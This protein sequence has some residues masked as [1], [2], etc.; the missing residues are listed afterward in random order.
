[1]GKRVTS[2]SAMVMWRKMVL[3]LLLASPPFP[4]IRVYRARLFPTRDSRINPKNADLVCFL[5]YTERHW[6]Y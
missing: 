4:T 5:F 6:E 3:L 1:M 2:M